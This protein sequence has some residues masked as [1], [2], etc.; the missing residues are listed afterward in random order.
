MSTLPFAGVYT[1]NSVLASLLLISVSTYILQ[2][3]SFLRMGT[4]WKIIAFQFVTVLLAQF[5]STY[6]YHWIFIP[7]CIDGITDCYERVN[8]LSRVGNGLAAIILMT[9]C[10]GV[11]LKRPMSD[12]V[13]AKTNDG[14]DQGLSK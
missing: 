13:I 1:G 2:P 10:I 7:G 9:A 14:L 6:Y 8:F 3:K 11:W 4:G 12:V 5:P